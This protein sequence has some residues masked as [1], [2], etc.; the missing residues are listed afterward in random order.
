M[1]SRAVTRDALFDAALDLITRHGF[2]GVTH[3]DIAA[4]AGMARTTFYEYFASVE[5][6]LVELVERRLPE[7]SDQ[8]VGQVPEHLPT[9]AKLAELAARMIEFVATDHLGLI[10]H[11]EAPKLSDEAQRRIA[12]A[13]GGLSGAFGAAYRAGVAEGRF[14]EMP[15]RLAGRLVYDV[16]MSAGRTVMDAPDPKQAVHEVTDAAVGFLMGGLRVA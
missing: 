9:D 15:D 11:T 1:T 5:D 12:A 2:A 6:L 14:R 3:A 7:M 8:I 4:T 16:I 13:H 10:L